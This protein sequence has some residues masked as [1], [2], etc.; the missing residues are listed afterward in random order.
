MKEGKEI[1]ALLPRGGA[2]GLKIPVGYY[3][4]II[5]FVLIWGLRLRQSPCSRCDG[6]QS[7]DFPKL[8][9]VRPSR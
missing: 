9:R 4:N 1:V 5:E 2:G 8:K 7:S 6:M 3:C